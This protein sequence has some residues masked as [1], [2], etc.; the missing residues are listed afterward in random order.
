[1]GISIRREN[2]PFT[3]GTWVVISSPCRIAASAVGAH[4]TAQQHI[5]SLDRGCSSSFESV[6][7]A[8]GAGGG[9]QCPNAQVI[10]EAEVPASA[11]ASSEDIIGH[12]PSEVVP[13]TCSDA[14]PSRTAQ[15][16]MDRICGMTKW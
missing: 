8:G 13:P 12:E 7:C 4:T 9:L 2:N 1:M 6:S 10:A 3:S 15:A 16:R 11:P 14:K 5:S